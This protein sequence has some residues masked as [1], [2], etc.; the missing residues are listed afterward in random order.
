MKQIELLIYI[1]F[2]ILML[3]LVLKYWKTGRHE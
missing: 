3:L 1:V 2:F